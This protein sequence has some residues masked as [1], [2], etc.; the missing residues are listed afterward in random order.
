[1][2]KS[3]YIFISLV[4][5]LGCKKE[6]FVHPDY[7][8][9]G[10][11]QGDCNSSCRFVY[12]LDNSTLKEDPSVKYFAEKKLNLFETA[13]SND[14]YLLAKDLINKV[15][16]ALTKTNRTIFIDLNAN[17]Q[18]LFYAEIKLNGRTYEWTFDNSTSSTPAYLKP[19]ADEM[20]KTINLIR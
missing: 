16:I 19:F 13:V 14:K 15:P 20:L 12:Y 10:A 18:N 1:M 5:L 2:K 17:N 7:L 8:I 11:I 9:F 3:I 6:E 4:F